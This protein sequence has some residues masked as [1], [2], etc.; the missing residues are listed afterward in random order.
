MSWFYG[1]HVVWMSVVVLSVVT[2]GNGIIYY[3]VFAL[4]TPR[5]TIA[6]K[7]MSPVS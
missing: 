2:A 4:A 3:A 6:F 1:L 7:L 5:R